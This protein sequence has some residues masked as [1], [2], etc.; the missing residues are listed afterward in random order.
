MG[1]LSALYDGRT[2]TLVDHQILAYQALYL[3][4]MAEYQRRYVTRW[5][6][7]RLAGQHNRSDML[8]E[9]KR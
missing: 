7:E 2:D 5:P 8:H 9:L 4:P 3:S 1:T 6:K